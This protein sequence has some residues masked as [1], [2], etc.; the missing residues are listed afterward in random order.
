MMPIAAAFPPSFLDFFIDF[1]IRFDRL[2]ING[3]RRWLRLF[4]DIAADD[5]FLS[6]FRLISGHD[7]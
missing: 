6:R 1:S 2:L 4:F 5:Y 7:A 3:A